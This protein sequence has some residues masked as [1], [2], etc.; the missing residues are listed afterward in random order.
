MKPRLS[1]SCAS[2]RAGGPAL[3]ASRL[4]LVIALALPGRASPAE[5]RSGDRLATAL[6]GARV[7]APPGQVIE[8]GVVVLRGGVIEA[9]GPEGKIAIP[10]DARVLDLHGQW[11]YPAFIEP[12]LPADRLAGKKRP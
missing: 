4:A 5:V 3:R 12:F 8:R 1:M 2:A 10:P 7:I 11:I 9:V 6:T